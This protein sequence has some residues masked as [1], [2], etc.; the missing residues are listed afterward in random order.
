MKVF[1]TGGTG[2]IGKYVVKKLECE[3]HNI[4]LLSRKPAIATKKVKTFVGNLADIDRWKNK[5]KHFK[6]QAT[7]HM[8]WEGLP[9]YGAVVSIKNLEYGLDLIN[10]LTEIG[11]KRIICTG[12]CWEYGQKQ[13]KVSEESP[14]E[15]LNAFSASKNAL[16]WLGRE[17]ARENDIAFIWTRIFYVYG[18]GQR[19]TSLIP[20]IISCAKGNKKPVIKNPFAKNDFVYVEDV[21]AAISMILK[22]CEQSRIYN[23]GSGYSVRV[24][25]IVRMIYDN[26]GLEYEDNSTSESFVDFWADISKINRD[27]GWEPKIDINEGIQRM[28]ESKVVKKCMCLP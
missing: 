6:P 13:G 20:Y 19:Q 2:F 26:F 12:S 5:V 25:D 22:N 21:A 23:I 27:L 15:P 1:V 24:K 8:A 7:I 16:Y 9:D 28:I 17:L 10:M 4:L 14:V 3:G 11:C 18:P